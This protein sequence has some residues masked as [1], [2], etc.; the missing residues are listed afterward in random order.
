M[1]PE[2]VSEAAETTAAQSEPTVVRMPVGI[3]S[4]ALTVIAVVAAA[5]ALQ[6][7]QEVFI[8]IVLSALLFYALDPPVDWLTA[9]R[10]PRAVAAAIVL[11]AVLGS[12][13]AGIYG[14]RSQAMDVVEKLPAAAQQAR[15]A[16]QMS[17]GNGDAISKMQKAASE[18][19][20][21]AAEAAPP[22][23]AP[24]GV[25]R[26]QVEEPALRVSEYLVWGSVGVA[27]LS[28]DLLMIAFLAYFLLLS[29]DLYKRK[30]VGLA[31]SL[32]RKKLTVQIVDQISRKIERFLLVQILTSALVGTATGVALWWLGMDQP[33]VWGVVAGVLNSVP[34]F[35]PVIVTGG[36]GL[37]AFTQFGSLAMTGAAAGLTFIIT[38]L[39]GWLLTPALMGRVAQMSPAAIFVGLIF[40]SWIWDVWGL[41][42]AVPMMMIIK[43]VCDHIEELQW[44]GELLGE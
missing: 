39:E 9:R 43:T 26:V 1:K 35:G 19:E 34:Y 17:K 23:Q 29:N 18:L 6:Y 16:L 30:L 28:G 22:G 13:G 44:F 5:F 25:V 40:W 41:L 11:L 3:R 15:R 42:L 20:K 4:G 32:S 21:T 27:K 14:L 24:R 36:V 2:P 37:V 8:P 38:V 10:V 7:A 12:V 33:A 31:P